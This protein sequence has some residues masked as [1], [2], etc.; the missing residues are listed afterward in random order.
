MASLE[1]VQITR[2][3]RI[4][5]DEFWPMITAMNKRLREEL[6]PPQPFLNDLTSTAAQNLITPPHTPVPDCETCG[7]C[8]TLFPAVAV[9]HGDEVAADECWDITNGELVVDR[10]VR[11]DGETLACTALVGKLGEHVGCRVYEHRPRT[12]REFEAGSDRC[13]AARRSYRLEPD[14]TLEEICETNR[15]LDARTLPPASEMI[16]HAKISR[17]DG[18][19]ELEITVTM[20]DGRSETVHVFDPACETWRQSEFEGLTMM[21]AREIVALRKRSEE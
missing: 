8:C 1:F 11:R 10:F 19:T 3:A 15:K 18:T 21:K 12:C 2:K 9:R 5:E 6:Y 4:P 20:T 16:K 7:A 13:H 17:R 14:L